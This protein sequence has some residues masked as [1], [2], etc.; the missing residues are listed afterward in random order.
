LNPTIQRERNKKT[1]TGQQ[2]I[3]VSVAPIKQTE[4]GSKKEKLRQK[5]KKAVKPIYF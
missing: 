3:P 5:K 2:I 4:N 1:E